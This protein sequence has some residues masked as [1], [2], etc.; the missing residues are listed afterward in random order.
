LPVMDRI[1]SIA[2]AELNWDEPRWT[3]EI[4]AYQYLWRACYFLPI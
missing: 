2:G 3:R 1:R 4:A